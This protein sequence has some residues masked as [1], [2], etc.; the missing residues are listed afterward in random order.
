MQNRFDK[1][2]RFLFF[3]RSSQLATHAL[4]AELSERKTE[5]IALGFQIESTL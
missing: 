5:N 4:L 2:A 1:D 3:Q